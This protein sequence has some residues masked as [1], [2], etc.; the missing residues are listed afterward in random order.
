MKKLQLLKYTCAVLLIVLSSNTS[1]AQKVTN[2]DI[3][4]NV[5]S[6]ESPLQKLVQLNPQVYEYNTSKYK[7]LN[8]Q[9]GRHYGFSAEDV[10]TLFPEAVSERSVSYMFGKNSYRNT[11]FKTVDE[12]KL[13]PVLVASIK[14]Q[15][16]QID[17]LKAEIA[18]LKAGKAQPLAVS[19]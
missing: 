17:T 10:Q 15:Q 1:F 19:E 9:A 11:S 13:I 12:S 18:A 3:K 4:K 2:S 7:H 16:L 14:E 8:L 5:S 6:I